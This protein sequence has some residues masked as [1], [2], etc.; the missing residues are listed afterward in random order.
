MLEIAPQVLNSFTCD[1]QRF[2]SR[3]SGTK[4][5]LFGAGMPRILNHRAP[6]RDPR[7]C[8][9]LMGLGWLAL[10]SGCTILD[11][12]VPTPE[13][14]VAD[15]Y[16]NQKGKAAPSGISPYDFA[17][18]RSKYLTDLI[19][20][21]RGFNF[22][23]GAAIARIQEA[24]AQVRIATQPLIPLITA[25]STASQSLNGSR[26]VTSSS[27]TIGSTSGAGGGRRITSVNAQLNGSYTL[28]IWGQYR[29]LLFAAMANEWNASF[30]ASTVILTT[31]ASIGI[32]YFQ[33]IGT[34]EQIEISKRNLAAASRIL[35]AIKDRF[36]QGTAN[37]L[38]VAQQQ[39]LVFNIAV[40]I[41]PLERQLQ[42]FKY[43]LAVL[44]G[45]APETF[46]Y[47][48]DKLFSVTVPAIP[49]G[50]PSDLLFRRPD[51]AS[52]EA[53][54]SAA[55]FNVSSAR[56]AM[57]PSIQ[58]TA[59]GGFQSNALATLFQPQNAFYNLAAGITQPIT[60]E[61]QLQAQLDLNRSTYGELLQTYRKTIVTAFQN[62]ESALIAY[63]KD[64]QQE[65][66]QKEAV[67][68]ARRA[69]QLSEEQLR[70]GI[71]DVT[72]L[73]QVQQTLFTAEIA[74]AQIRELR[75][76]DAVTL[77]QALGGGWYKPSNSG[78]ANVASVIEVK[79]KV[80]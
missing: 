65:R 1:L 2:S 69:F 31:D 38:D 75:L 23:I 67:D 44:V 6:S 41:P 11:P 20:L 71:I 78:I 53:Q 64:A 9:A 12:H 3:S 57:F 22:D 13:I 55:K 42:Q 49:S 37:G 47:R 24:E 14:E 5:R 26:T 34:Q 74:Y 15:L 43:A 17:A 40:T 52:A 29:S 58:L 76:Q 62:V 46:R 21:G 45:Q 77:Y 35:K 66:L 73:L 27:G 68:S 18:F 30:A 72:T 59:T 10:F 25:S 48:G 39:T 56:A 79:A 8:L 36:A 61:Y 60:N 16:L 70:G 33:A 7:W 54:L 19:S 50:L 4:G 51:I 80:P 32:T 28:D 63:A